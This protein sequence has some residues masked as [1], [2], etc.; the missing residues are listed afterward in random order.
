MIFFTVYVV[1]D[2]YNTTVNLILFNDIFYSSVA[3]IRIVRVSLG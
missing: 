2:V 1:F 3:L